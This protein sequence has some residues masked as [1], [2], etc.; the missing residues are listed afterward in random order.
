VTL[1][2]RKD[3]HQMIEEVLRNGM[4]GSRDIV[5]VGYR[6]HQLS[7]FRRLLDDPSFLAQYKSD[8][9]VQQAGAE[10]AWQ[11]FF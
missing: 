3:G 4:V 1:L 6:K 9:H 11:H 8:E 10:A 7:V 5:N 2:A